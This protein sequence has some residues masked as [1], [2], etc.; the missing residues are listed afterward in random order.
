[1]FALL[2]VA[3]LLT[4]STAG[5][6]LAPDGALAQPA[7][8]PR[9][10]AAP[11]AAP[12]DLASPPADAVTSP[13]GLV[14]RVLE[15]GAGAERPGP[16]DLAT[17]HYTGWT[18]DGKAFQSTTARGVPAK[19]LVDRLLPGLGEGLQLMV[20]GEKRRLWVPEALAFK[21]EK[22]RP[23]GPLVLDVELVAI[24]PDPRK[25]PPDLLSPPEDGRLP[26]GLASRV[27]RPGTGTAKPKA[28][29]R[30]RV[31]Y[32]GWTTDGA[33]FDSSVMRGEPAVFALD[34]VIRGWTD[35]VQLMVP[36][37]KRR[38]WIPARLA[39]GNEPGKPRGMLVFDIELLGIER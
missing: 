39:Y 26:S 9:P 30:V 28:W 34:Q 7:V 19:T 21:G 13:S 4:A 31:H 17:F 12:P 22:G 33:M 32:T 5:L 16:T 14:S 27:L 18:S 10:A 3:L 35:G 23:E 6:V 11:P 1:M 29:N 36:G 15:P 20:P 38:F 24:D 8:A 37:E 2:R 25:A